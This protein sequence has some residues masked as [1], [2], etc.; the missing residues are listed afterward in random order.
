M[1]WL[2]NFATDEWL[3]GFIDTHKILISWLTSI[4]FFSTLSGVVAGALKT[5]A[6]M[7]TK[8][9]DNKVKTLLMPKKV[10]DVK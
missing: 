5:V 3:K 7:S 6:I 1:E 10:E 8:A 4:G 9:T 2:M